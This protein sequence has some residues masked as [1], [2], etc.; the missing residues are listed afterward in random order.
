[1]STH[2]YPWLILNFFT[3][4]QTYFAY[5]S[6]NSMM[7]SKTCPRWYFCSV[8]QVSVAECLIVDVYWDQLPLPFRIGVGYTKLIRLL[9]RVSKLIE[10]YVFS[11]IY[12]WSKLM[13]WM[14]CE[15]LYCFPCVLQ[16]WLFVWSSCLRFYCTMLWLDFIICEKYAF[17]FIDLWSNK[18]G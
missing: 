12:M 17:K 11:T 5:P 9:T 1:M 16:H 4:D 8:V 7:D 14:R 13:Y 18:Y 15:F 6:S 2:S 3:A 10:T